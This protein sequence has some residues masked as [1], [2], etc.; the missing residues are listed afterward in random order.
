MSVSNID[1]GI[2]VGGHASP[3]KVYDENESRKKEKKRWAPKIFLMEGR[4]L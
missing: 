1:S 2:H 3:Q 4:S